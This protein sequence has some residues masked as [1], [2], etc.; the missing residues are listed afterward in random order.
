MKVYKKTYWRQ[1]RL[2]C[3]VE[4]EA[5]ECQP[6]PRHGCGNETS[7]EYF[8]RYGVC[9]GVRSESVTDW[10]ITPIERSSI[11]LPGRKPPHPLRLILQSA[12]HEQSLF[13]RIGMNHLACN[14]LRYILLVPFGDPGWN[15]AIEL[16][17][18]SCSSCRRKQMPPNEYHRC[19]LFPRVDDFNVLHRGGRLFQ[20]FVSIH[21]PQSTNGV[22]VGLGKISMRFELMSTMAH[23][24][25]CRS[26]LQKTSVAV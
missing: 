2:K 19:H 12:E 8:L 18:N 14:P 17:P 16:D 24:T 25:L 5:F 23:K 4:A 7:P 3:N 9:K 13:D 1:K 11:I 20:E 15:Y 10:V 6:D 21:M 22:L 26:I